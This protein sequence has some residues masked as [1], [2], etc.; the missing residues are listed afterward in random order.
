MGAV[1]ETA[2]A[3]TDVD[4]F[5]FILSADLDRICRA[6]NVIQLPFVIVV[7]AASAELAEPEGTR[8]C[9][10]LLHIHY[11]VQFNYIKLSKIIFYSVIIIVNATT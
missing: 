1:A 8:T 10:Q 9:R 2:Q 6:T 4:L 3:H 11:L 7:C 5:V